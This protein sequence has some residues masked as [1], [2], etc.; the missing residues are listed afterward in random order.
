VR[1]GRLRHLDAAFLD[2]VA[3]DAA[4]AMRQQR[5]L[6]ARAAVEAPGAVLVVLDQPAD[7]AE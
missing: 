1:S 2:R 7:E 3:G 4:L 6:L 5:R